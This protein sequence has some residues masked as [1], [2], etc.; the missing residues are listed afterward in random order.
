MVIRLRCI[1]LTCLFL[2]ACWAS[3]QTFTPMSN[4]PCKADVPKGY[5]VLEIDA[6]SLTLSEGSTQYSNG[7]KVLV[8]VTNVN[9]F[10]AKYSLQLKRQP[11]QEL[12]IGDFL[13]NVGGIVSG[14]IPKAADTKQAT[15]P[16]T[17]TP[18]PG[19]R[20]PQQP[21]Q[22]A[23]CRI[24]IQ[25]VV[26]D[27][28]NAFSKE[29][30]DLHNSVGAITQ[31]YATDNDT[32]QKDLSGVQ[33]AGRCEVAKPRVEDL[34]KFLFSVKSPDELRVEQL[35][36]QGSVVVLA[37]GKNSTEYLTGEVA[38]LGV[39]AAELRSAIF[40]YKGDIVGDQACQAINKAN[41]DKLKD[42][43]SAINKSIGPTPGTP[44]VQALYSQV[45]QLKTQYEQLSQARQ[46]IDQTLMQSASP[47]VITQ[48][49]SESQTDVEITLK[50]TP[51]APGG[52]QVAPASKTQSNSSSQQKT[53]ANPQTDAVP[54][55]DQT[56]HF[57]YGARFSI[58]GGV[59][60]SNL[61][62]REFTTANGQ[63]AYQDNSNTRI[64]PMALLNGRAIDCDSS[65]HDS[66]FL[67]PQL[68]FGITAKS[69]DKGTAPEYLMGVSWVAAQKLF[70]TLGAYDGQQQRLLGGLSVGQAT[71]LSSANLP[72]AKEYHWRLG[73]AVS[74]KLK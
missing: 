12:N 9:P 51:I 61:A 5:K 30:A 69:D 67:V 63:I 29:E 8:V 34:R 71:T 26:F 21:A 45:D 49:V 58:S 22:L 50:A 48:Y 6:A 18:S 55:F 16:A 31:T 39:A 41:E 42:V 4:Y 14:F 72:V 19:A 17:S 38:K 74:W 10:A 25:A 15:S 28:Y 13:S 32:Y 1:S 64:L 54:T 68:S 40:K 36:A 66:C 56:I 43:E 33:T 65:R 7:D 52:S 37:N 2:S 47:F 53:S 57:G 24:S 73:F 44:E 35:K 20:V 70:L 59:A 23:Q 27:P 3:G 11:V 46:G 60:V 62:K